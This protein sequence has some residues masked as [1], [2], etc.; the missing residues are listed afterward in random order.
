MQIERA[1]GGSASRWGPLFGAR[2]HDWAETWE[3]PSGWGTPVYQHVLDRAHIGPGSSVLDCGCGAGRFARMAADRG[4]EVAGIDASGELID[5]AVGRTPEGDF[6]VG[7]LEALPW[8]ADSF[9]LVTGFSAYQFADDKVKA[10]SEAGRVSRDLTA[11]IIPTRVA[12]SGIAAVFK[13]LFPL[14]PPDALEGMRDSGMF[15]LSEPGR[16]D[17]ALANAALTVVED[18][19]IE[20][21]VAFDSV[22]SAAR[23]FVGAGPMALAIRRSGEEAVA[24]TVRASLQPFT[25]SDGHVSLAAWYR[26]VLA[27]AGRTDAS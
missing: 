25:D 7:D 15:A 23:A 3:G 11:V 22:D 27:C 16:L 17:E 21:P 26:V 19:E 6:R 14:F 18:D 5:V 1:Q 20:F 13:P 9:D 12:S 4:A 10:L 24:A 8:E 2:A